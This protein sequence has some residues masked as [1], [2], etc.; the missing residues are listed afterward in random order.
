MT[1]SSYFFASVTG[2]R[3]A[4]VTGLIFFDSVTSPRSHYYIKFVRYYTGGVITTDTPY[5]STCLYCMQRFGSQIGGLG[6]LI[7]E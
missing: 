5:L 7:N 6:K 1:A 4:S 3:F 2:P